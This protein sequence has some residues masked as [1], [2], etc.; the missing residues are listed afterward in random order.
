[1]LSTS[2]FTEENRIL[3]VLSQCVLVFYI[4]HLSE[5][6]SACVCVSGGSALKTLTHTKVS[7]M[8]HSD[9]RMRTAPLAAQRGFFAQ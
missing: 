3:C 9:P 7:R 1:M 4:M 2:E 5:S 6:E 8:A